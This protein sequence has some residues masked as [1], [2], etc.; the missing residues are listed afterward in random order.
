MDETQQTSSGWRVAMTILLLVVIVIVAVVA[1]VVVTN[2]DFHYYGGPRARVPR[3]QSDFR[4]LTTAIESYAL[5]ADDYPETLWQLTTPVA[6]ISAIPY[7]VF[8]IPPEHSFFTRAIPRVPPLYARFNA[9]L[10]TNGA[11]TVY[12]S[13]ILVSCGPDGTFQIDPARDLP[14]G[15]SLTREQVERRLR[16]MTWDP[17]NG[18]TSAG[19][20]FRLGGDVRFDPLRPEFSAGKPRPDGRAEDEGRP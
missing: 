8:P 13:W 10:T 3:A 19:D 15:E 4:S 2:T 18:S 1:G 12:R 17:S 9:E 20:I 16:D 5:D 7:D 11:R 14:P 6:Y